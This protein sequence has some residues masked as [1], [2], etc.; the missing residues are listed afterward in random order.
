MV[1]FLGVL[2]GMG[3]LATSDFLRKL[4]Q[5]TPAT[6]DQEH[7]PVLVWGDCTI[8]D[9]TA[10]ILGQGPSPLPALQD[11]IRFLS[12]HGA[13]A[14]CIPCNSAHS[15]YAELQAQSSVPILHI[16]HASA[17][18]VRRKK[19]TAQVVGVLSTLGTHRM[20]IYRQSLEDLGFAVRS[21]SDVEFETLVSP[22]IALVKANQSSRAEALYEAAA[23]RLFDRGAEIVVLGCTEIPLSMAGPLRDRPLD[24]VD[25]TDALVDAALQHFSR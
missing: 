1:D 16:V 21:S 13:S 15:W 22:A 17:A 20:G 18:Q 23:Q 6:V 11:G 9:R 3:P 19:P 12:A 8:P 2:G 4:V 5:K 14:I 24:F 7:V 10:G 25:S